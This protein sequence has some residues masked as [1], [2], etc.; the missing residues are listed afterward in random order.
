M[1]LK[2]YISIKSISG[3][4]IHRVL[5]GINYLLPQCPNCVTQ[6]EGGSNGVLH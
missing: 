1:V 2:L 3:V 4:Y 5:K 6:R